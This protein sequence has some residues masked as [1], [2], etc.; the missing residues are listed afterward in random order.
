MGAA[1]IRRAEI[2]DAPV[3]SRLG[4]DTF[5]AAFG[6]MYPPEDLMAFLAEAYAT[7][8]FVE[9]L[10]LDGHA[11][12]IAEADGR[13]VG[14]AQVGPCTLPHA[15]VTPG[16]GELKRLYVDPKA[17]NGG[18]GGRL[19]DTALDWLS[20]PGR[21]LWIGVWSKNFGAQRFYARRG[22]AKVGEYEFPVG[23]TRDHEFVLSRED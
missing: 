6:H 21:R 11:L 10:R 5:V 20:A 8:T 16:C 15:E 7:D 4:R 18:L 22:F 17:Q 19:A 9:Y 13:A 2:S 14:Y 12:W 23:A 3:L 1:R